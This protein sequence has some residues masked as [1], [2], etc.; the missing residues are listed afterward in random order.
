M[1]AQEQVGY[2]YQMGQWVL[3]I[4]AA[5]DGL[6]INSSTQCS[7][8]VG[9]VCNTKQSVL[10]SITGRFG[11]AG[12]N[13]TLVYVAGGA[14]FTRFSYAETQLLI[15]S[16]NTSTQTG[17]TIGGG[18]EYALTNN[19]IAGIQYNYYDFGT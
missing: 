9:S 16:W 18:V 2:N 4:E 19:W 1:R 11:Y 13:R 15:Q 17:W 12:F 3:G 7:T 5:L 14:A 6:N 10:G 8:T